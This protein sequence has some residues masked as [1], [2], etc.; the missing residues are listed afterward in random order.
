MSIDW[1]TAAIGVAAIVLIGG[2]CADLSAQ[3]S[4]VADPERAEQVSNL[5]VASQVCPGFKAMSAELFT[6]ALTRTKA[7]D[8]SKTDDATAC[9]GQFQGMMTRAM[10]LPQQNPNFCAE[11]LSATKSDDVLRGLDVLE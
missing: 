6:A 2:T 5:F 9:A 7:L 3:T 8:Q 10:M 1:K 4:C 11:T